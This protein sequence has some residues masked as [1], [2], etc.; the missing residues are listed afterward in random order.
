MRSGKPMTPPV[1]ATERLPHYSNRSVAS[2]VLPELSTMR[3]FGCRMLMARIDGKRM[4]R[5]LFLETLWDSP[6]NGL[7][8]TGNA[9][10]GHVPGSPGTAAL[11][12][13]FQQPATGGPRLAAGGGRGCPRLLRRP[14]PQ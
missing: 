5:N 7:A 3:T 4:A 11:R 9:L 14:Q 12:R 6:G 2:T 10:G 1:V 8:P 13:D